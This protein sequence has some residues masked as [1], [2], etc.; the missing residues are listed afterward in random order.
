M[1]EKNG[2]GEATISGLVIACIDEGI[3]GRAAGRVADS[4]ARRLGSR[5]ML[6][7]VVQPLPRTPPGGDVTSG[8]VRRGRDLLAGVARE[9]DQAADIRVAFGEPAERLIALAQREAAELI[10]VAAPQRAVANNLLLGSV[11]LALAGLSPCPVVVV[12]PDVDGRD[13]SHVAARLAAE[14]ACRLDAPPKLSTRAPHLATDAA[15]PLV[16]VP[17]TARA[18]QPSYRRSRDPWLT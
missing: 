9:L 15:Q 1:T 12:P 6:A 18:Q 2:E 5:L 8:L 13:P 4:L 14:L 16:I 7:T 11:W 17:P 3:G 10:V